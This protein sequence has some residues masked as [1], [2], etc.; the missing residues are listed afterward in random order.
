MKPAKELQLVS[1][2]AQTSARLTTAPWDWWRRHRPLKEEQIFSDFFQ[3]HQII[4]AIGPHGCY[5]QGGKR[6][7]QIYWILLSPLSL[8]LGFCSSLSR[9]YFLGSSWGISFFEWSSLF[10]AKGERRDNHSP[11]LRKCDITQNADPAFWRPGGKMKYSQQSQHLHCKEIRSRKLG[12][13][14]LAAL[15]NLGLGR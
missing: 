12:W 11:K 2:G 14:P 7:N 4:L 15:F 8:Q 6:N 10:C 5:G 3:R 9:W 1:G 13:Q